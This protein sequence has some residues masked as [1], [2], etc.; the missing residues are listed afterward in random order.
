MKQSSVDGAVK[1]CKII[2]LQ[3]HHPSLPE[4]HN[5]WKA[6]QCTVTDNVCTGTIFS[7]PGSIP[8]SEAST[9][10]SQDTHNDEDA[11]KLLVSLR[12]ADL[13]NHNHMQTDSGLGSSS[14]G[15]CSPRPVVYKYLVGSVYPYPVNSSRMEVGLPLY[16]YPCK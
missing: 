5:N 6:D 14:S 11:A 12:N 10:C 8:S 7:S 4:S 13:R 9:I 2:K 3:G 15:K 1:K 16:F